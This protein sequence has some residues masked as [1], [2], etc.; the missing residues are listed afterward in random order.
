MGGGFADEATASEDSAGDGFAADVF[1]AAAAEAT[2]ATG[3][4]GC[5]SV[6]PFDTPAF[7]VSDFFG[8]PCWIANDAETLVVPVAAAGPADARDS[9]MPA[10]DGSASFGCE[11]SGGGKFKASSLGDDAL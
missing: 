9:A 11:K 8:R 7:D 2:G 1:P 10:W 4:E 6:A 3:G 5:A